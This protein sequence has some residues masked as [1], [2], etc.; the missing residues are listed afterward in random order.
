MQS[1]YNICTN[2]ANINNTSQNII[3]VT[4]EILCDHGQTAVRYAII[5]ISSRFLP[6]FP[7]PFSLSVN[8]AKRD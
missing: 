2:T 3:P 6:F 1:A 7:P 5:G 4:T 8:S